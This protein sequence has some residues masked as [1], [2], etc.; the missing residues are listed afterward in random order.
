MNTQLQYLQGY[1]EHILDQIQQLINQGNLG[2]WL[3]KRYPN[4]HNI[5]SDKALFEYTMQFKNRYLK[6]SA[7][8]SKVVYCK[9]IHTVNHALGLHTYVSKVHG[10]KIKSKNEIRI[11]TLFRNAPE[12]LLRM[13]VV[14]ELAHL[15]EKEHNKAFYQL[16]CHMEP[17][18]HQL[19]LDARLYLTYQ[20]LS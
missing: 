13:L 6:K 9:K 8:L 20:E 16:C 7:P 14:H 11:A 15:K 5:T 19:E 3:Q 17:D 18:Y 1:P 4:N 2:P 10:G 12:P